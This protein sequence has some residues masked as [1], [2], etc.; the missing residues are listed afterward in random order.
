MIN[1]VFSLFVF[2][3]S[4]LVCLYYF[5]VY[6]LSLINQINNLKEQVKNFNNNESDTKIINGLF[7]VHVTIDPENDFVKLLSF[8]KEHEN[9]KSF[10]LVFAVSSEKNN[11]YMLSY[12]SNKTSEEKA[13]ESANN[14]AKD[15]TEFG[16][17]VVRVKVESHNMKDVPQTVKDYEIYSLNMSD[18]Y[19]PYFEFHVKIFSNKYNAK[20]KYNELNDH[21][22]TNDIVIGS[23]LPQNSYSIAISHNICSRN[24]K[25]ILTIR[26]YNNGYVDALVI[27]DLILNSYKVNGF[28][29]DDTI[30]QEFAVFDSCPELDSGWL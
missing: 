23:S 18:K 12:F 17:K 27:K 5:Y 20:Y 30:Q 24:K 10:K 13:I 15:M 21:I 19:K 7:E 2:Y 25:P 8:V 22:I 28:V 26:I 4:V 9:D 29:F 1:T 3:F 14:V 6:I 11:Q 16:L